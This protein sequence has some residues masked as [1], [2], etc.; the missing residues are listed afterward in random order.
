MGVCEYMITYRGV[1]RASYIAGLSVHNQHIEC[2]WRD[3][4]RCVCFTFYSLF[5]S[6]KESGYL[7]LEITMTFMLFKRFSLQEST[8]ASGSLP[9]DGTITH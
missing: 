3:V 5:Y 7:D 4:F 6:L 2:M 9:V 8:S 1:D